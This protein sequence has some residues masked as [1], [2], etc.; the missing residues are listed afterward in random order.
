MR[1]WIVFAAAFFAALVLR[2]HVTPNVSLVRRG[3]FVKASLPAAVRFFE[4][5]LDAA[6]LAAVQSRTDWA[7]SGSDAKLYVGREADGR[8]VGTVVFLW[9]PSQHGPIGIGVAFGPDGT[10]LRAAVTDVGT[11]PLVWVRPLLR[12][13][14]LPGLEGLPP[15]TPPDPARI[16]PEA[17]GAMSRYYAGVIAEGVA[18]ARVIERASAT[19]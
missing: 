12:D 16:A 4:K 10:V 5:D 3:D 14:A 19:R 7:L 17:T 9:L 18:R 11:E 6:A 1:K 13:G 2:A 8:L 15:S